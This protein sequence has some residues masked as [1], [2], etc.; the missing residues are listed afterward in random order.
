MDSLPSFDKITMNL[1]VFVRLLSEVIDRMKQQSQTVENL[2]FVSV[3]NK[4]VRGPI[5]VLTQ[6]LA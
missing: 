1:Y 5:V 2:R 4:A 6:I 3:C